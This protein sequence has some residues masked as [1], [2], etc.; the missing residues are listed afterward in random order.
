MLSRGHVVLLL[1]IFAYCQAAESADSQRWNFVCDQKKY[2][3][4]VPGKAKYFTSP[5]HHQPQHSQLRPCVMSRRPQTQSWSLARSGRGGWWTCPRL[6]ARMLR[7]CPPSCPRWSLGRR[8]RRIVTASPS[9]MSRAGSGTGDLSTTGSQQLWRQQLQVTTNHI[10]NG[11]NICN[12][13]SFLQPSPQPRQLQAFCAPH[14]A[15]PT[16]CVDKKLPFKKHILPIYFCHHQI[17]VSLPK[18]IFS[19]YVH[20]RLSG[21]FTQNRGR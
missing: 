19:F 14:M 6:R 18:Y 16:T 1:S 13:Y 10:Y 11:G 17:V 8:G 5:P 2:C 12:I 9:K 20:S 3:V 15:L 4:F 7:C 21:H